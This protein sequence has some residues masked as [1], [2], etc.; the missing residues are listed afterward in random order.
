[1]QWYPAQYKLSARDKEEFEDDRDE[2]IFKR[3]EKMKFNDTIKQHMNPN[4]VVASENERLSDII[5]R[6]SNNETDLAVVQSN[7]TII[8]VITETD[9]FYT[10]VKEIFREKSQLSKDI[11]AIDIL[12]EPLTKHT[13]TP[14]ETHGWHPCID[15]YEDD[16]IENAIRIMQRSGLHHL[17]VFDKQNKLVG[18]LSSHDIIK[19]FKK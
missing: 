2:R 10:L 11:S 18:T 7:D 1:M 17:L 14:C 8:G 3:L 13:M 15:A 5:L 12:R 4:L 9:I 19:N 16:T 6:M